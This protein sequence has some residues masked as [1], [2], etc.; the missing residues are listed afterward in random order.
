M[1]ANPMTQRYA[2]M[3]E[4]M[5]KIKG[6]TLGET[7]TISMMGRSMGTSSEAIEVKKGAIPE[8]AFAIPAGYKKIESPM[9]DAMAK[10][11][12]RG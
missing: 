12:T 6:F 10:M 2:K 3:F 5:K 4:E 1:A 7:T 11:K 9:K 8:S